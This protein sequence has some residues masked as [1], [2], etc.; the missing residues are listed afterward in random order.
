MLGAGKTTL[1]SLVV[2]HLV[3]WFASTASSSS[4]PVGV[5]FVYCDS[6]RRSKQG[7]I[8][9][10][11]AILRQLL[12]CLPRVP[13]DLE[14]M[15]SEYSGRLERPSV[16]VIVDALRMVART[17]LEKVFVVRCGVAVDVEDCRGWTALSLARKFGHRDV[18]EFL[19]GI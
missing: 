11:S 10:L 15:Y 14:R 19:E 9:V 4:V 12:D 7:P 13:R 8:H 5:A 1:T 17:E 2:D 6:R 16:E 3:N 18:V